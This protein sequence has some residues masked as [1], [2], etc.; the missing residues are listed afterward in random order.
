MTE[1]SIDEKLLATAERFTDMLKNSVAGKRGSDQK[2]KEDREALLRSR[3]KKLLPPFVQACGTLEDFWN[4]IQRKHATYEGRRQFIDAE[5]KKV[6]AELELS[7]NQQD[8]TVKRSTEMISGGYIA[9]QAEAMAAMQKKDPAGTI[10]KAKE[11]VET[12][13]RTMLDERKESYKKEDDVSSLVRKVTKTLRI[14]PAGHS[15]EGPL[16]ETVKKMLSGLREAVNGLTELGSACGNGRN[17]KS[18]EERHAK[19][20]AGCAVAL[21]QFLWDSRE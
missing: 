18:T 19:L 7:V 6:M 11:L 10:V 20:A 1:Q 9:K 5:F 3:V 2:Y 15:P 17:G 14:T 21:A 13:C 12:V 16:A 4:F 8:D